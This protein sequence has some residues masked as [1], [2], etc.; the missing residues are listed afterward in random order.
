[1]RTDHFEGHKDDSDITINASCNS[2]NCFINLALYF[3]DF[4]LERI[5]IIIIQERTLE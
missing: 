5:D 2:Y 4:H 3:K 1:V